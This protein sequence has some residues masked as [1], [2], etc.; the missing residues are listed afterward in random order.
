MT[1]IFVSMNCSCVEEVSDI[2]IP[3]GPIEDDPSWKANIEM[4]KSIHV[5]LSEERS[6]SFYWVFV[7]VRFTL[8]FL[9]TPGREN[10]HL[11]SLNHHFT[12]SVFLLLLSIVR[13][14]CRHCFLE[15][16]LIFHFC[17]SFSSLPCTLPAH[18]P[19]LWST[20]CD[21]HRET[22]VFLQ[23]ALCLSTTSL[24]DSPTVDHL[25]LLL[26]ISHGMTEKIVC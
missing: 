10:S 24:H 1:F 25:C 21:R 9:A 17:W 26:V 11:H 3:C 23:L 22:T 20:Y 18:L 6:P 2:K 7:V 15:F 8:Y 12:L 16:Q 14:P 13:S 19:V 5:Q 4:H